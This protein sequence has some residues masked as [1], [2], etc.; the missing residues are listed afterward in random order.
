MDNFQ[1]LNDKQ[2]ITILN[3]IIIIYVNKGES[4]KLTLIAPNPRQLWYQVAANGEKVN[5]HEQRIKK[6]Y[7]D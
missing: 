5:T 3:R 2:F 1:I 4:E 6:L 7:S